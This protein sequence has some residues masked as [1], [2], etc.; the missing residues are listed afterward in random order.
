MASIFNGMATV[1]GGIF[2]DTVTIT[3]SG[4]PSRDIQ[5]ILRVEPLDVLDQGGVSVA[6]YQVWV[7]VHKDDAADLRSGDLI[8]GADGAQY[9]YV[10]KLPTGNPA[11]DAF[12][13]I[14]LEAI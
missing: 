11:D 5:G 3:P 9:K 13:T 4:Q 8:V 2:G 12:V 6:T 14:S 1:L 10:S 7:K